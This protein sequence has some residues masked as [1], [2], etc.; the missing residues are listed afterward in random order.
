[1]TTPT[2]PTTLS[3]TQRLGIRDDVAYILPMALFLLL[4][5][6]AGYFPSAYVPAYV[7][8]AVLAAAALVLCW[9]AYTKIRWD[10]WWLGIIVGVVGIVQWVVMQLWLQKTF[11]GVFLFAPPKDPFNPLEAFDSDAMLYGFLFARIFSATII[12]PVM[13]ELFWRDYLWRTV[14]APNDFKLASVG[15][16]GWAPVL[17]VSG[18]F[19]SVHGHWWLTSIVWGLMIAGLLV[20][21]KSLGACIIA[22]GVTNLLLAGYVLWTRDWAFW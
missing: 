3:R 22:H 8:K 4:T 9:P 18:A 19:A 1:M 13:E 2:P 5:G 12:V 15:E 10:Y 11:A 17:I 16:W 7:L 6:I 21:T 20:Y 14:L